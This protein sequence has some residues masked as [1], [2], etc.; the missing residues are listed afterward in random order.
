[1]ENKFIIA[2][3]KIN[4]YWKFEGIVP[5]YVKSHVR[6]IGI[7]KERI[8]LRKGLLLEL[9]NMNIYKLNE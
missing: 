5:Q 3:I 6:E 4:P 7:L 9:N 1:M 2:K 8:N